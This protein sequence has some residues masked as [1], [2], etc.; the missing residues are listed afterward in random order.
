MHLRAREEGLPDQAVLLQN[1]VLQRQVV[2]AVDE[3]LKKEYIF[4]LYGKLLYFR[5]HLIP[6]LVLEVLR[7]VEVLARRLVPVAPT[8]E[9]KREGKGRLRNVCVWCVRKDPPSLYSPPLLIL[10]FPGG[11]LSCH[12]N[13]APGDDADCIAY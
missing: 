9:W 8:L 4:N 2:A 7:W 3:Q 12:I 13:T 10:F 6:Y 5:S 1:G 11:V